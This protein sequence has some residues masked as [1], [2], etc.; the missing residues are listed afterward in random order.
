MASVRSIGACKHNKTE[1]KG[2]GN[3]GIAVISKVP[4][5]KLRF[6]VNH[7]RLDREGRAITAT[8]GERTFVWVYA[9]CSRF[10][11][12]AEHSLLRKEWNEA[13]STH[14][15]AIKELEGTSP[16]IMEDLN[17][18]PT[19]LDCTRSVS[20]DPTFPSTTPSERE[21][22]SELLSSMDSVD[23]YVTLQPGCRAT[24]AK[25]KV[26]VSH[27]SWWRD[28]QGM[29]IDHL[30]AP[31]GALDH[32]AEGHLESCEYT[33]SMFGSDH[34]AL[35][36][37]F[38]KKSIVIEKEREGE[39]PLRQTPSKSEPMIDEDNTESD[40]KDNKN[41][42]LALNL[43][44][45]L[46]PPDDEE[47]ITDEPEMIAHRYSKKPKR[48]LVINHEKMRAD[49]IRDRIKQN[50][51]HELSPSIN[52]LDGSKPS[53][54]VITVPAVSGCD[55]EPIDA[56]V[57]SG[58]LG[59]FMPIAEAR[60]RDLK[61][62]PCNT[63][64]GVGDNRTITAVGKTLLRFNINGHVVERPVLL[65]QD[66]PYKLILGCKFFYEYSCDILFSSRC[67]Q[68]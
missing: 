24:H 21:A 31:K 32:S 53:L 18:A 46:P 43:V 64:I 7:E 10:E 50:S 55:M 1:Q 59:E 5:T 68:M 22:F 44:Q 12:D 8:I 58:A 17:V 34:K 16:F 38:N 19:V 60:R 56:L 23:A 36:A 4:L 40:V 6:G 51:L 41:M 67:L 27:F 49:I 57:D 2:S 45:S 28:G 3:F 25:G 65:L 37:T 33:L 54:P 14:C 52:S 47:Y 66:C 48:L 39:R 35:K 61:I 15:K 62:S 11:P 29:R 30:L 9:P 20:I 26:D 42:E 13:L 63:I